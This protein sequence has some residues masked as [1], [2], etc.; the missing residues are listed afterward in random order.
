MSANPKQIKVYPRGAS[1]TLIALESLREPEDQISPCI[2]FTDM[3]FKEMPILFMHNMEKKARVQKA[4][5]K[6]MQSQCC[7]IL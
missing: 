3:P 1:K 5:K 6:E 4:I 7:V 2:D